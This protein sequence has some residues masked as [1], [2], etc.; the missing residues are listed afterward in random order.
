MR[1]KISIGIP[2]YNEEKN[3][4]KLLTAIQNQK[5]S[6]TE[7]D[8]IVVVSSGSTDRTNE[9]V[10]D[11]A[12]KDPRIHLVRQNCRKGK[13]SAVNEFLRVARNEIL[14]LESADTIPENDAIENLCRVFMDKQ[15]G[16]AGAH[17]VPKNIDKS[18]VGYASR[19][20]W[21]LHHYIA[22]EAPK[23]GELIAFRKVFDNIPDNTVVDEAWIEFEITKRGYKIVY[24]PEAL[25]YNRGPETVSDFIKQRRRI[26]CGHLALSRMVKY[27]VS[28]QSSGLVLRAIFKSFPIFNPLR[29]PHFL[30]ATFL[31][32]LSRLMGYYD[33]FRGKSHVVWAIVETT[34]KV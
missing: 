2:A 3:I 27:R 19:L 23:C 13:A 33:Y 26:A 18:L 24:V 25:V 12:K 8:Q 4:G 1:F 15:V 6:V 31:E 32:F 10:E 16:M 11:F 20:L 7:I 5:T 22:L 14:V 29:W 9:I 28:T 21:M 34:K 17:P 30:G